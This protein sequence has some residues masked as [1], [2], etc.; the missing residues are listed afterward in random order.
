ME[1]SMIHPTFYTIC[2][3]S[4][5]SDSNSAFELASYSPFGTI[6]RGD[7]FVTP[8]NSNPKILP[9]SKACEVIE[10]LHHVMENEH[11]KLEGETELEHLICLTL[12]PV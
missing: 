12:R 7:K 9:P 6:S 10:V 5:S 3:F 8:P 1:K 11:P 2:G 4:E